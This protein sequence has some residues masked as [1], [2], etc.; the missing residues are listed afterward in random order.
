M[1]PLSAWNDFKELQN[2][3]DCPDDNDETETESDTDDDTPVE[4]VIAKCKIAVQ[5]FTQT[6]NQ[7]SKKQKK[8]TGNEEQ[9][10]KEVTS[11]AKM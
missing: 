6:L 7:H 1:G 8:D 11:S 4:E 3:N 5:E 10:K 9:A 2:F